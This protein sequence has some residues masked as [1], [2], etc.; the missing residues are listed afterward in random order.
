[1][2]I[3]NESIQSSDRSKLKKLFS[4]S[5]IIDSKNNIKDVNNSVLMKE[6]QNMDQK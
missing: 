3:V 4:D 2:S 1:M 6:I 5:S